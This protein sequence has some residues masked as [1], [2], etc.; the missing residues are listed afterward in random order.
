MRK[1]L[2]AWAL[3][4]PFFVWVVYIL[5]R[6]AAGHAFFVIGRNLYVALILYLYYK[7]CL[8][9]IGRGRAGAPLPPGANPSRWPWAGDQ[10][11]PP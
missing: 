1:N 3:C 8:P 2:V 5:F 7:A 11:A 6:G 10:G 4:L 9:F